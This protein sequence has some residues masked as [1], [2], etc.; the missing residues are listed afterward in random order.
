LQFECSIG[1]SKS[2]NVR[3]ALLLYPYELMG[4]S[5]TY[6]HFPADASLTVDQEGWVTAAKQWMAALWGSA[7]L[8]REHRRV[9]G[10]IKWKINH[11]R[12][13]H[14]A[15]PEVDAHPGLDVVSVDVS[16]ADLTGEVFN[17]TVQIGHDLI[18]EGVAYEVE[19]EIRFANRTNSVLDADTGTPL[20][21]YIAYQ[22][23]VDHF[24]GRPTTAQER[25]DVGVCALMTAPL[26]LV[27]DLLE[28]ELKKVA[29]A[30]VI[31][32][33]ADQIHVL[34]RAGFALR[35]VNP[36]LER[37]FLGRPHFL[38]PGM[39]FTATANLKPTVCPFSGCCVVER[40][41]AARECGTRPWLRSRN[42]PRYQPACW[43]ATGVK[44]L[45][46]QTSQL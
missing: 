27:D 17:G 22:Q 24:M 21:P 28:P 2:W 1:I 19:R 20:Y 5:R 46:R 9:S 44:A 10:A 45:A 14:V 41:E 29:L 42:T 18:S 8:P 15:I 31:R 33:G 4:R 38:V 32:K 11:P 34:F 30:G 36:I 7:T 39:G 35:G 26:R 43:Y 13:T 12:Q 40:T 25:I 3:T 37:N 6:G 23:I 16:A